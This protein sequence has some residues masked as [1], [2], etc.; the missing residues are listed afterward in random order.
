MKTMLPCRSA[1]GAMAVAAALAFAV[2]D[3]AAFDETKYPDWSGQWVR[4]RGI[5]TQWDQGKPSGLGQQAPLTPEYQA[6]LEASLADQAA[7]GQG[8]DTRYKCITNGMPRVMAAIFPFEFVILP[9]ITYVNFEAFMPRRIYTDG[10][11]FPTDEEPSFMGYSLG[12]WLDTDGDGRFDTLE[13]ETRN[14]KGPRTVEF[15][16]IALHEDNQTVVKERIYLDKSDAEVMHNEIT[17]IDHAFTRPWTVDKRYR[18]IR[19]VSWYEDNCNEN[20]NHVIIGKENYFMSGDGYLM[21]A[22]KGQSPPDLR[23][24]KQPPK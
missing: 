12:K 3:A 13:V 16:G 14:F 11:G 20:N 15:T 18:R 6:K 7:G 10:R 21:P 9:H 19:K 5:A 4:P 1:I 17:I 2:T 8:L 23:Y 24:F 22:R